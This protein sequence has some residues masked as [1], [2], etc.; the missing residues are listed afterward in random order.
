MGYDWYWLIAEV[1]LPSN[2]RCKP[3]MAH[4]CQYTGH[5]FPLLAKCLVNRAIYLGQ[6]QRYFIRKIPLAMHGISYQ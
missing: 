3:T 5:W 6:E 4:D 1:L 2:G